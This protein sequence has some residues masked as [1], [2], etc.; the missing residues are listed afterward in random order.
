MSHVRDDVDT[1]DERLEH[2]AA[3]LFSHRAVLERADLDEEAI[4]FNSHRELETLVKGSCAQDVRRQG[5]LVDPVD[6]EIEA[7]PESADDEC[8]DG[9]TPS[10]GRNGK[11]N[12]FGHE[13]SLSRRSTVDDDRCGGRTDV[14]LSTLPTMTGQNDL[15]LTTEIRAESTVLHVVGELDLSTVGVFDAKLDRALDVG[16]VV[17]VLSQ[18]TFID[19]SALQSLV[20]AHR[21]VRESND[22]TLVLVA[23]SQP[24]RRVLEIAA[25]DRLV[26]V[27]DTLDD[28]LASTA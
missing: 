28:A 8:H 21:V 18:C 9:G 16:R 17:V 4:A 6:R 15:T 23:P 5:Q 10:A 7:R 11:E 1:V 3:R 22:R 20:R 2:A 26:P 25:L 13:L 19:S 12:G 14:L 27:F 24:A